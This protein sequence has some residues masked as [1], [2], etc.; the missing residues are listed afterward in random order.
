LILL[1]HPDGIY[2]ITNE[3]MWRFVN[4]EFYIAGYVG[5][6]L[7]IEISTALI[8][9][10]TIKIHNKIKSKPIKQE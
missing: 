10:I 5:E 6:V 3:G 2:D 9:Y 4:I 7:L 1:Y 8:Y